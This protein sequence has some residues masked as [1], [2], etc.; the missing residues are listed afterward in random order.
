MSLALAA[1]FAEARRN[2]DL[3]R[4]ERARA[5]GEVAIWLILAAT[6]IVSI[7]LSLTRFGL[8]AAFAYSTLPLTIGLFSRR[9]DWTGG[10]AEE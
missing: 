8:M 10:K 9:Y 7:L 6:G 1:L 5:K 4:A 3:D 2:P